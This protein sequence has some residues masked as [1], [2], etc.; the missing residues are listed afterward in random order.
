MY[1]IFMRWVLPMPIRS[2]KRSSFVWL[3]CSIY[4]TSYKVV[5]QDANRVEVSF[6][7]QY[8]PNSATPGVPLNLDKRWLA[9]F[10]Q[11]HSIAHRSSVLQFHSSGRLNWVIERLDW[12]L[13]DGLTDLCSCAGFPGSTRTA[14]TSGP[15][16]GRPSTSTKHASRSSSAMTSMGIHCLSSS[17]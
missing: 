5:Y 6:L 11:P 9:R 2:C 14:F 15:A 12:L 7:R 17:N 10:P 16:A 4:G 3:C 1:R 8:D 13:R